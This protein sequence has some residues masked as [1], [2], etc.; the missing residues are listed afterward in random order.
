MR[1]ILEPSTYAPRPKR[2][3]QDAWKENLL[4]K[5]QQSICEKERELYKEIKRKIKS[6]D[7]SLT[8]IRQDYS[9]N[10]HRAISTLFSMYP[11]ILRVIYLVRVDQ[12]VLPVEVYIKEGEKLFVGN[13]G[14]CSFAKRIR[15]SEEGIEREEEREKTRDTLSVLYVIEK[16]RKV[17]ECLEETENEYKLDKRLSILSSI[18]STSLLVDRAVLDTSCLFYTEK[19]RGIEVFSLPTEKKELRTGEYLMFLAG[20]LHPTYT[21]MERASISIR[22]RK[23]PQSNLEEML[24]KIYTTCSTSQWRHSYASL[25]AQ[26]SSLLQDGHALCP[27][28]IS[29]P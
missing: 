1:K 9:S 14:V 26:I 12:G 13:K 18:L 20:L 21:L 2:Y 22:A 11:S 29:C 23:T 10:S 27:L 15:Y 25:I 7:E 28:R 6:K 4:C 16:M 5:P 8:V 19:N 17:S 3:I 24:H